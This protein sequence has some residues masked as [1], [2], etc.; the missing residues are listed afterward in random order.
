VYDLKEDDNGYKG[1]V[2]AFV[3]RT[4]ITEFKDQL[5][6]RIEKMMSIPPVFICKGKD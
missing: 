1:T 2:L 3:A 6:K 5:K 4:L